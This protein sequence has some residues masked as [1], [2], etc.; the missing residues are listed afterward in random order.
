[1]SDGNAI[2]CEYCG[3]NS[4][5]YF[6]YANIVDDSEMLE[7][8]PIGEPWWCSRYCFDI[9]CAACNEKTVGKTARE[10]TSSDFYKQVMDQI[11]ETE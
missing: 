9:S 8:E 11:G 1:M 6:N 10:F 4:E 2:T 7:N 3:V 5:D